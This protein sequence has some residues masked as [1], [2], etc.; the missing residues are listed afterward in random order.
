[1]KILFPQGLEYLRLHFFRDPGIAQQRRH[2]AQMGNIQHGILAD[3]Q[4]TPG[5]QEDHF[6]Q[7]VVI[8]ITQ[9]LQTHLHHLPEIPGALADPVD[10]FIV[11]ELLEV[12]GTGSIFHDG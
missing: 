4:Q 1:M 11:V 8:D 7:A 2:Q 3:G 12:I 6:R 10:I 9:T 5:R